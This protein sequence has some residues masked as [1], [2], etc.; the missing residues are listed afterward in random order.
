MVYEQET[1]A[2]NVSIFRRGHI[3]HNLTVGL[4]ISLYHVVGTKQHQN[5]IGNLHSVKLKLRT[6]TVW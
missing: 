2:M 4:V 3:R 5:I 6:R 1:V